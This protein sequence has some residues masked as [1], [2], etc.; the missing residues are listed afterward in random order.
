MSN[1][2]MAETLNRL[3]NGEMRAAH[4][5]FEAGA[6]CTAQSL[7]GCA[8]YLLNHAAEELTHMRKFFDYLGDIDAP[9]HFEALPEPKLDVDEIQSLFELIL[10]HEKKVT[11]SIHEA[12]RQA[13][14]EEDYSTREF[15][16]WFV[17]EQREEE[18]TFR[19]LIDLCKLVGDGPQRLYYIDKEVA[20]RAAASAA[21]EPA[22]EGGA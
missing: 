15:L 2:T 7:D 8:Q 4:I 22:A 11:K 10:E 21:A 19:D 1:T 14:A 20:A 3:M 16:Q 9:A 13:D 18:K 17:M 6:W 5:Y 12:A